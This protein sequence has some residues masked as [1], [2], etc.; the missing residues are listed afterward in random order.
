[1]FKLSLGN[2]PPALPWITV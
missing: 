2:W 1:M